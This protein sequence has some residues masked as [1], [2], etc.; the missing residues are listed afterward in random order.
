MRYGRS[1]EEW[2]RL[3]AV[4]KKFLIERATMQRTTTYTELNAALANRTDTAGFNF[5]LDADRAAI[6]ELLGQISEDT[7]TETGGLL[8]SALVQYLGANDAGPGFYTLARNSGLPVPTTN[9]SRQLFW[10]GHVGELHRHYAR[11]R[12]GR[13]TE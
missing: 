4:G 3:A 12:R 1:Q 11:P 13:V 6:G 10:A 8:I 9:E 7:V 2:A 5:D